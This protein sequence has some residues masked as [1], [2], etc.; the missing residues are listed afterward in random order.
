VSFTAPSTG[1]SGTFAG[2]AASQT[3]TTNAAGQAQLSTTANSTV[4][5]YNVT[6]SVAGVST[7]AIFS[8]TNTSG[9]AY[10]GYNEPLFFTTSQGTIVTINNNG[11]SIGYLP[12]PSGSGYNIPVYWSTP[13]SQPQLLQI[14]EGDS[15]DVAN[16]FNDNK[17]IVGTGYYNGSNGIMIPTNPV[18]W[19]SPTAKPSI[20]AVPANTWYAVATS[21]NNSGQIVGYAITTS[22]SVSPLY[23]ASP[24]DTPEVLQTI[25]GIRLAADF[26]GANGNIMARF[27]SAYDNGSDV[28]F[29]SDHS[30][31]PVVLNGLTGSIFVSPL[32]VNAAGVF[33]GYCLYDGYTTPVIW[34][35]ADA[36]PQA[37][38]LPF[39]QSMIG[40][41]YAASIN[42]AGVIVGSVGN[43]SGGGQCTLW[44]DGQVHDI[45]VL[46]N[47]YSLGEAK[48]ITDSGWILGTAYYGYNQYILI[49]K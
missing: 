45:A 1:Q 22:H 36:S 6:A 4:G 11:N 27:G 23:W 8:L 30:A 26:I 43:G 15:S 25:A 18:Y 14:S 39:G 16:G 33:V 37:L 20:L 32:S 24:T 5:D 12:P 29:W 9:G 2:G 28:A 40:S 49:P 13:T 19:S 10:P 42:S 21:I 41:Y 3:E 44:K 46:T 38:P 48:L 7:T 31:Q 34:P 17:Q 35:N 47:N